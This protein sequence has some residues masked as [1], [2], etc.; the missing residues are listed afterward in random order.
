MAHIEQ[1]PALLELAFVQHGMGIDEG[2][3]WVRAKLERSWNKL[4]PQV[5]GIMKE[6][7]EA[8]LITLTTLNQAAA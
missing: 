4:H 6:K 8:A 1:V 7:Y 2:T 3:K 5:Q